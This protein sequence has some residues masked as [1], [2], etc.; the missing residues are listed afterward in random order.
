[1]CLV[2]VVLFLMFCLL[3]PILPPL[4]FFLFVVLGVGFINAMKRGNN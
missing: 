3:T 2:F 4:G 1:M